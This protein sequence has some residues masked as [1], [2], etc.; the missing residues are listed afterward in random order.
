MEVYLVGG[1]VR[2]AL[3]GRH[4]KERDW[5]VVGATPEQLIAQGYKPV[6][7]DFPVFLHPTTNEE[8]ALARTERK[9]APGY[10]GF[11]FHTSPEVTL[12]QDLCRRDL[13]INAM[14][15]TV[16][17]EIID[18]YGGKQDLENK[19]LRHVSIAFREDPLRVLRVARFA[20]RYKKL[21]FS[22]ADETLE[23][24][25]QISASNELQA[26]S[27]ER[28][29]QEMYKALGEDTP[30]EFFRILH[31]CNALIHIF[32]ELNHEISAQGLNC[33]SL[34]ALEYASPRENKEIVRFGA[35]CASTFLHDKTNSVENLK[36]RMGTLSVPNEYA[37]L[38]GLSVAYFS[39]YERVFSLT[40]SQLLDLLMM[41]DVVRKPERYEL[42]LSICAAIHQA[43]DGDAHSHT[44]YFE[45]AASIVVA[46]RYDPEKLRSMTGPQTQEHIRKLR[47]RALIQW[48]AK[49]SSHH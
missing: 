7:K 13:T 23:L 49:Q 17:G 30:A 6:G 42:W 3:L 41:L 37:A 10:K 36:Q 35:I 14:A 24:M 11:V 28:I 40:A 22:I 2:D 46:A 45:Q 32:P 48:L 5:V 20:A 29:W 4:I 34:R 31:R 21:G 26:L 12:E 15:Q 44:Q 25:S 39:K 47:E 9:V 38:A 16:D 18:P 1:A 33:S 8:Y 19:I 27:S 43:H